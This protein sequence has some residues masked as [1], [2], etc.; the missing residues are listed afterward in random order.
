VLVV[1]GYGASKRKGARATADRLLAS[2]EEFESQRA[3]SDDKPAPTPT[4]A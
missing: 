3:P 1:A 2:I 4:P